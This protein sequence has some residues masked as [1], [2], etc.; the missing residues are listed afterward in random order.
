MLKILA[1][2]ST[3]LNNRLFSS[4]AIRAKVFEPSFKKNFKYPPG[5]EIPNVLDFK[6]HEEGVYAFCAEDKSQPLVQ[7]LGSDHGHYYLRGFLSTEG[8]GD[9]QK[10]VYAQQRYFAAHRY[11]R[12]E[13]ERALDQAGQPLFRGSLPVLDIID[14]VEAIPANSRQKFEFEEKLTL[15]RE[16]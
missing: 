16:K 14:V 2:N 12:V 4:Q 13:T 7:V 10:A 6:M 5:Y 8:M 11:L 15:N 9:S 3:L 1:T